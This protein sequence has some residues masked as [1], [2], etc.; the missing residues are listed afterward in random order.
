MPMRRGSQRPTLDLSYI[1][2]INPAK[3][4]LYH[5]HDHDRYRYDGGSVITVIEA[6]GWR[7]CHLSRRDEDVLIVN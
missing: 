6:D 7:P 4:K 1:V 5:D 3:R 2:V